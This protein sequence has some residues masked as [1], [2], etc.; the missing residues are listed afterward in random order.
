M[1]RKITLP[2]FLLPLLVGCAE[3][4]KSATDTQADVSSGST[5]VTHPKLEEVYA[6]TMPA[7]E[8]ECFERVDQ[9]L[10]IFCQ[11]STNP[12]NSNGLW[13]RQGDEI[14]AVDIP[15]KGHA[16]TMD[17][18]VYEQADSVD[19]LPIYEPFRTE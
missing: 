9:P 6:F 2:I 7:A 16:A 3:K 17:M 14:L 11:S 18:A 8:I 5:F 4:P 15:A 12:G 1:S 19:V 10:Y 13:I